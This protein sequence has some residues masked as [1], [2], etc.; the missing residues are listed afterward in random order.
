MIE[1]VAKI[2]LVWIV[3]GTIGSMF[4]AYVWIKVGR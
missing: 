2:L 1:V 4:W 3:G